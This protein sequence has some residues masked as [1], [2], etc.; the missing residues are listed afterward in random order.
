MLFTDGGE[1]RAQAILEKF[2][3][4]KKVTSRTR[5]LSES[6]AGELLLSASG[7]LSVCSGFKRLG[8]SKLPLGF[9]FA[10]EP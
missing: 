2:N 7:C 4:E 9:R 5:D 1:E 10:S 3:P 6:H 8:V